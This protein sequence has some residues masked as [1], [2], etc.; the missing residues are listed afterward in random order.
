MMIES[1]LTKSRPG[2][3]DETRSLIKNRIDI[4]EKLSHEDFDALILSMKNLRD[5]LMEKE[6]RVNKGKTING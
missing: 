2:L 1:R 4:M 6:S 5:T 3:M